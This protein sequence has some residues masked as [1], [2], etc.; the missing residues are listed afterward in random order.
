MD[1]TS[2]LN[3]KSI[4]YIKKKTISDVVHAQVFALQDV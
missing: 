3:Y 1:F 4:V 2:Y